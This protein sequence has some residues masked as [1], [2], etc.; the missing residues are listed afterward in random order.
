VQSGTLQLQHGGSLQGGSYTVADNA[1]LDLAT[2]DFLAGGTLTGAGLGQVRLTGG[3][4]MPDTNATINVTGGGFVM[5]AGAL[6]GPGTLTFQG[7]V[8]LSGSA[9]K[10]IS[11]ITINNEGIWT[12]I[13]PGNILG[14]DAAIFNNQV[15][16]TFD[17]RTNG[18]NMTYIGN[19]FGGGDTTFNNNGAVIKSGDGSTATIDLCYNGTPPVGVNVVDSCP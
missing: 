6:E 17:A 15:G 14:G 10:T 13:G 3:A 12:W 19:H 7:P 18:A 16:A 1:F 9:L 11:G 4:L 5:T 8:T 2:N